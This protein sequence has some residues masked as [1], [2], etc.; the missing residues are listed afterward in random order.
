MA[1]MALNWLAS[2]FAQRKTPGRMPGVG[3]I[4]GQNGLDGCFTLPPH[5]D[6]PAQPDRSRKAAELLGGGPELG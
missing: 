6:G 5:I 3:L 4:G 2:D 1:R